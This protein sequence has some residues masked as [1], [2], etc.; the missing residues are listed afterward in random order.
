[1]SELKKNSTTTVTVTLFLV[2]LICVT[3]YAYYGFWFHK[4]LSDWVARC[5]AWSYA[6]TVMTLRYIKDLHN[7]WFMFT[8]P[9]AN[10]PWVSLGELQSPGVNPRPRFGFIQPKLTPVCAPVYVN[11][12]ARVLFPN[13]VALEDDICSEGSKEEATSSTHHFAWYL[14]NLAIHQD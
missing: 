6:T 7:D 9:D 8:K 11:V 1:M 5:S 14:K 13:F 2:M 3:N 12:C 4:A 10:T